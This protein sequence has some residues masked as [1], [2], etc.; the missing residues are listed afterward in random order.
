MFTRPNISQIQ[1]VNWLRLYQRNW[2]SRDFHLFP[3]QKQ[4]FSGYR[5][6]DDGQ[7]RQLWHDGW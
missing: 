7:E 1:G 3:A 2:P 6:K 5:I 4:N